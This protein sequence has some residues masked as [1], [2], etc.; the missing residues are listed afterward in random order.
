GSECAFPNTSHFI[1]LFKKEYGMT[2]ATFAERGKTAR[3]GYAQ[4]PG[5]IVP[6]RCA[7][8]RVFQAFAAAI[9]GVGF[10]SALCRLR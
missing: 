5:I 8:F 3:S 10:N 6:G 9:S 4:R 1:K 7:R 2:P